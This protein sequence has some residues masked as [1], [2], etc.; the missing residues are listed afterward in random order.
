MNFRLTL[1]E[2]IGQVSV[3]LTEVDQEEGVG[4]V[5]LEEDTTTHITL[6]QTMCPDHEEGQ[7]SGLIIV[8]VER[9]SLHLF[10]SFPCLTSNS[11]SQSRLVFQ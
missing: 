10:F 6:M 1:R 7:C 5:V 3:Q 2:Q 8:F 9:C 11:Q 4:A